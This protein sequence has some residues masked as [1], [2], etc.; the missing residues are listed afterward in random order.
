M[1]GW[2]RDGCCNTDRND[3]GLHTVC[4]ILT[5]EFL[6]FARSKGNDLITPDPQFNF[7]GLKP[8]DQWCVCAQTWQDAYE[9]GVACKVVLEATHEETLQIVSLSSLEEHSN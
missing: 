5:Q 4:C 7:P 6:E 9:E 8:G 2:M 3:R 1:T